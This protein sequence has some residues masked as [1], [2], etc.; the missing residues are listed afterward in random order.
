MSALNL[1]PGSILGAEDTVVTKT[2]RLDKTEI[3]LPE[4]TFWWRGRRH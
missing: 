4:L 1:V 2:E 3:L